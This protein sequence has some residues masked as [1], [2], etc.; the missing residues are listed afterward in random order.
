MS[1][2]VA[3]FFDLDGTLLPPPSLEQ[4]FFRVLHYRREIPLKNYYLWL[5]ETLKLFP[6]GIDRVMHANKMYLCGVHSLNESG[7]VDRSD[8]SAHK[9]GHPSQLRANEEEGQAS[10]A[11]RH[12]P[13]WSVPPF[14][15]DGVE[16]LAWH[17][18]QGHAIV[19]VSGTLEPLAIAAARALEIE[20]AVRGIATGI[21]V[22]ATKLEEEGGKW[23]GRIL[24]E[25][26]C[27]EAKARAV[28]TLAEEMGLDLSQC[29]AYGDSSLDRWMLEA[30]ENPTAVNPS[31]KLARIARKRGWPLLRWHVKGNSTQR[32]RERRD[33]QGDRREARTTET[34]LQSQEFQEPLRHL[35]RCA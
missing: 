7:A 25:A 24:G 18:M 22:C 21:R 32:G 17:A 16:R 35:E 33:K 31:P 34:A 23:T 15:E 4:R 9:S 2:Q 27:V 19:V 6:R 29:W 11:P 13:L 8:P 14:F 12:N 28:V 20:L 26:M 30:V 10:M 1:A 5:R 3:A